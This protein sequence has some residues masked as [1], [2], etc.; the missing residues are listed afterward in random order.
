[1]KIL[2]LIRRARN[3][4]RVIDGAAETRERRNHGEMSGGADG[5]LSV[6]SDHGIGAR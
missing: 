5:K 6:L 2:S 1:M 4:R 3:D